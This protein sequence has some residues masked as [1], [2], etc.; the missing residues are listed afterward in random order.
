VTDLLPRRP[1]R[2]TTLVER[3]SASGAVVAPGVRL[4]PTALALWELC[5]GETGVDEMVD[6]VAELFSLPSQQ[7]RSDVEAA[8]GDMVALGVI[9]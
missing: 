4:N 2:T 3:R 7:A 9:R 6:A 8:L 1:R 5:D